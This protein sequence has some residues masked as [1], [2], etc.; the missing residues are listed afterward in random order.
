VPRIPLTTDASRY[1]TYRIFRPTGEPPKRDDSR[2]MSG[3]GAITR[4]RVD[5][6]ITVPP[7]TRI[8]TLTLMLAL[9]P[10]VGAGLRTEQL[11][12]YGGLP[13]AMVLGHYPIRERSFWSPLVCWGLIVAIAVA[14]YFGPYRLLQR[15]SDVVASLD[16][17]VLPLAAWVLTSYCLARDE[18]QRERQIVRCCLA[19]L[20]VCGIAAIVAIA[21]IYVDLSAVLGHFW[22]S[23]STSVAALAYSQGRTTGVF[24]QPAEAGAAFSIALL[25]SWRVSGCQGV[26]PKLH[27]VATALVLIAGVLS[28]SKVFLLLGLPLWIWLTATRNGLPMR[29]RGRAASLVVA[30]VMA[31]VVV[32]VV[33]ARSGA[34]TQIGL[35]WG[36]LD[37]GPVSALSGGRLGGGGG[38]LASVQTLVL[39]SSPI[40]G[41]GLGG[42]DMAY[43]ASHVEIL[44]HAGVVGVL[45]YVALLLGLGR[46]VLTLPRSPDRIFAQSLLL[47]AALGGMG[48]P[49]L[50]ANRVG[51]AWW[52]LVGACTMGRSRRPIAADVPIPRSAACG[53]QQQHARYFAAG[54]RLPHRV[55][56]DS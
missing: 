24:N 40:F 23:D 46:T 16:N 14:G 5:S 48:L 28:V 9:G 6:R 30:V 20:W 56:R 33:F 15:P 52:V 36:G 34:G 35:S 3:R 49:I 13:L 32:A 55:P 29:R 8:L 11:V 19:W 2:A 17:L 27:G 10:Y 43:D 41:F 39:H 1:V 38:S 31:C 45:L 42:L 22:S 25:A 51:V 47:L 26:R 54:Q 37:K 4:Q 53:S 50:T 21:S 44:A 18:D 12:V 7:R